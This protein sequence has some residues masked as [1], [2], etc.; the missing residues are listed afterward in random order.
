MKKLM[1]FLPYNLSHMSKRIWDADD[2]QK[3]RDHCHYTAKYRGAAHSLC[4]P[5]Y[6]PTKE[7]PIVLQNWSNYDYHFITVELSEKYERQFQCFEAN[8]EG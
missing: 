8:T 4:N 2:N 5:R 3:V 6:K 1:I 7:I